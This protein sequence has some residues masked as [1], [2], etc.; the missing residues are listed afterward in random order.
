MRI[1]LFTISII[2]SISA[3]GQEEIETV[4]SNNFQNSYVSKIISADNISEAEKFA[5]EDI[6]NNSLF[7]IVPGGIAPIIYASDFDFKSKY[8]VSIINFGCEPLDKKVAVA[9][10]MKVFDLL[11]ANYGKKWLKEIRDDVIGLAE[12]KAKKE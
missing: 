6:E 9:Y 8:G 10:N 3:F 1:T 4:N 5:K 11:I 12:Y 2:L 7:L